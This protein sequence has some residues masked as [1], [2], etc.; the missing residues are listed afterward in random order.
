[1]KAAHQLVSLLRPLGLCELGHARADDGRPLL[2]VGNAGS[3][4]WAVFRTSVEFADGQPNPLDRWTRRVG[5]AIAN[6]LGA[7]V[8]FPFDGPPYPPFLR[9]SAASGAAFRSPLSLYI[10]GEYGLW[11]AHRFAL[12]LDHSADSRE[13][14]PGVRSP[15][16]SCS[17]QPCLAACPA[18][19]FSTDGYELLAC[20]GELL[21]ADRAHCIKNACAARR[22]CPV[23]AAYRYESAHAAF[24]MRAFLSTRAR[25]AEA[26]D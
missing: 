6:R 22:A 24:H 15:C 12:S 17:D 18:G 11:H 16:E 10:H 14:M 21:G 19:A 5:E 7:A 26:V 2:L 1:M 23:A 4:M 13:S 20:T 3:A 25:P 8:V 9:W